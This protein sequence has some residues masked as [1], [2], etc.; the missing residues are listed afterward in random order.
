MDTHFDKSIINF[1][2]SIDGSVCVTALLLNI[3][4]CGEI[5]KNVIT[6]LIAICR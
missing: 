2:R 6:A 5:D 1:D 3:Y 4:V